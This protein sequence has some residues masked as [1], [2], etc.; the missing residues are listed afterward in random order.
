MKYKAYSLFYLNVFR[1]EK[2][3][4]LVRYFLLF[5]VEFY[6][7][8]R[9]R[10]RLYVFLYLVILWGCIMRKM[11]KPD[12][13]SVVEREGIALKQRGRCLW[14]CCPLNRIVCSELYTATV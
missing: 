11:E 2:L 10:V 5:S 13:V 8:M 12:L 1:I 7:L 14:A 4:S 3:E 6:Q 9:C